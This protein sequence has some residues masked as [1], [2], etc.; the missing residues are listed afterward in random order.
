MS[1][2][3]NKNVTLWLRLLDL[4]CENQQGIIQRPRVAFALCGDTAILVHNRIQLR[5]L[6]MAT[7]IASPK[8]LILMAD[9]G[10]DPTG[11]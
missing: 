6:K 7:E 1:R 11:M 4:A 3:A 8:V 5:R 9:Y 10:H 2:P